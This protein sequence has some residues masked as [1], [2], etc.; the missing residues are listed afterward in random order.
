[1]RFLWQWWWVPAS[2]TMNGVAILAAGESLGVTQG[3][4]W[5]ESMTP[6]MWASMLMSLVA[7]VGAPV[8]YHY[9]SQPG[10]GRFAKTGIFALGVLATIANLT[11]CVKVIAELRDSSSD[12][13]RGVIADSQRLQNR[14]S[15]LMAESQRLRGVS[16]GDPR[17]VIE[18]QIGKLKTDP[19]Y[20]RSGR[21]ENVS[22]PDSGS[23]CGL[24]A[25]AK[26]R[27]AAAI[28]IEQIET[29]QRTEIWPK[30]TK[31]ET[32]TTADPQLRVLSDIV[33]QFT[34]VNDNL[35]R[36]GL[37]GLLGVVFELFCTFMPAIIGAHYRRR[38]RETPVIADRNL[39]VGE[40]TP[41][42]VAVRAAPRKI[43]EP[44]R[45]TAPKPQSRLPAPVAPPRE[46]AIEDH[47]SAWASERLLKT[48]DAKTKA[49]GLQQDF[50]AWCK[51]RG[52][53]LANAWPNHWGEAMR[54]LGY[55]KRGRAEGSAY[56]VYMGV[57][58]KPTGSGQQ[59]KLAIVG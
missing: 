25:G 12:S 16:Q 17:G 46:I 27:L 10:V 26:I 43:A 2:I 7:G 42:A 44:R 53:E 9:G 54:N 32:V 14:D 21:C 28:R 50:G 18:E 13:R 3:S 34:E 40:M 8:A 41:V 19:L 56:V 36:S 11:N 24:I 5:W 31:V 33:H 57:S 58:L 37:V 38:E 22:K 59:P 51:S 35:I 4:H 55:E 39:V 30:L 29:E 49:G 20:Q 48:E 47:V 15:Q 6:F 45:I 1:M 23:T 52:I